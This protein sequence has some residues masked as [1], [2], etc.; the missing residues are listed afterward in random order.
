[1]NPK[2]FGLEFKSSRQQQ[3]GGHC[4]MFDFR[5]PALT[6]RYIGENRRFIAKIADI[7]REITD[8]LRLI[9]KYHRTDISSWNIVS[10][11]FDIVTFS[12]LDFTTWRW[13]R[14]LEMICNLIRSL[15]VISQPRAISQPRS[16]FAGWRH[17]RSPF[18]SFQMGLGGC[19]M[20]LVCQGVVS[21]LWNTLR[22][23]ASGF[24][25]V[26]HFAAAKF[27]HSFM[28]LSSND[29][30]FFVSTPIGAPFEALDSWLTKLRNDI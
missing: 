11:P 9:P 27:S 24:H 14:N 12:S 6:M 13:F 7:S 8:F 21:Q 5:W 20:V 26:A 3:M 15:E 19:E 17:F 18:R 25:F 28:R 29:H 23:F 4:S 2:P 16:I 30:N 22:N 1:M 10:K